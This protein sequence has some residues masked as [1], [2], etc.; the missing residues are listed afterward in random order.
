MT[1]VKESQSLKT[2][3]NNSEELVERPTS[4][5][6]EQQQD[7][8]VDTY[9]EDTKMQLFQGKTRR[10][11]GWYPPNWNMLLNASEPLAPT[12]TGITEVCMYCISIKLCA[13]IHMHGRDT[14]H[15]YV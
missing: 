1:V 15:H 3:G 9:S 14:L 7:S 11:S 13:L 4:S 8:K 6:Q 2:L 5:R 10:D 12:L